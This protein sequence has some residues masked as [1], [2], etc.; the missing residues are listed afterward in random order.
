MLIL[1]A[2]V[3]VFCISTQNILLILLDLPLAYYPMGNSQTITVGGFLNITT[4]LLTEERVDLESVFFSSVEG[5]DNNSP[6]IET[7]DELHYQIIFN[8]VG[9]PPV[10]SH[11]LCFNYAGSGE[12]MTL[13]TSSCTQIFN[14]TVTGK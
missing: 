12:E 9:V 8:N 4:V 3:S 6:H 11:Q 14:L 7:F 13:N 2:T 1:I 10:E 5:Y